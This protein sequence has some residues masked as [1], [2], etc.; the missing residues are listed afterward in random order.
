MKLLS[1]LRKELAWGRRKLVPLF[2]LF[3]LLPGAFA[4]GSLAFQTVLPTDAPVAVV[5]QDGAVG[6]DDVT[7]TKGA[8]TTFSEPRTYDSRDRAFDALEREQVYAVV[9]VPNGITDPS[10][11]ATFEVYV[12]GSIVPYH[13]ASK[14]VVGVMNYYLQHSL[15][16]S[17]EVERT[18]VGTQR[19]LSAYLIPTFLMVLVMVLALAYLPYNLA[20][21]QVVL[22]RL[23]VEASLDAVI[24]GKLA[25]FGTL[26]CVPI[27]VFQT[28]STEF[29]Y[30]LAAVA[31][32]ALIVY[33]LTFVHLGAIGVAI[34]LATRFSTF[35]RLL[36]LLV[37]FFLLGFSGLLYP[38]GFFSPLRRELIR[39]LPTHYAIVA[40]RGFVLRGAAAG[41]YADWLVGLVGV[42]LL[43]LGVMKLA[44][45]R[46]ERA[47]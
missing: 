29:G 22:D 28:M 46:Y 8:V 2:I 37:L 47:Q 19:T 41:A 9:T 39:L 20:T 27:A 11:T 5:P 12:S 32:G 7:I 25:F 38:A 24:A 15:P 45:V 44:V 40:A 26:L 14:A 42:T 18:I 13:E 35:G 17:V 23:R 6:D 3:V 33:L 16:V 36:N 31:P 21:E 1:F 43:S 30:G 4:Y 10:G 34:T